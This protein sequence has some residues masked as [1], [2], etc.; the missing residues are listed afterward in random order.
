MLVMRTMIFIVLFA[1]VKNLQTTDLYF[2]QKK[3]QLKAIMLSLLIPYNITE[4]VS[5]SS[6]KKK[7]SGSC[8][9]TNKNFLRIST[10]KQKA[11]VFPIKAHGPVKAT[12]MHTLFYNP[13]RS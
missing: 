7:R 1:A 5:P 3:I 12:F 6:E 8:W 9:L 2:D 13:F 10:Y 11:L 4:T